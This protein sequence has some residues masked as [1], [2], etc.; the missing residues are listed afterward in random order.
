MQSINVVVI[1]PWFFLPF[2]GAG[3]LSIATVVAGAL[4]DT[5]AGYGAAI[6]CGLYL[7]GCIGVTGTRNVPLNN[8]LATVDPADE[9]AWSVW[10]LYLERWTWWNHVRTAASLAAA[11]AFVAAFLTS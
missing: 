6:G 5:G 10:D 7:F 1:N 9:S 2:F 8:L 4:S 3:A 11:I